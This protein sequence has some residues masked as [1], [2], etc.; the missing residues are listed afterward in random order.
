[1]AKLGKIGSDTI[2]VDER[3]VKRAEQALEA[4]QDDFEDWLV[5]DLDL[6]KDA[7]EAL[8][9]DTAS[10]DFLSDVCVKAHDLKGLGVTYNYPLVTRIAGSLHRL[11]DENTFDEGI[12]LELID[13]HV[14]AI[15]AVVVGKVKAADDPVGMELANELEQIVGALIDVQ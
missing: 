10:K 4:L 9:A 12:P 8:R 14:K 15:Q 1:M 11:I 7:T 13:N 6:L 5:G 3:A 2:M